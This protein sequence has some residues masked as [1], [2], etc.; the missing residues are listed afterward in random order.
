MGLIVHVRM[1]HPR[2]TVASAVIWLWL[3]LTMTI[4]LCKALRL[5]LAVWLLV[6]ILLGLAVLLWLPVVC[7]GVALTSMAIGVVSVG[8]HN[9]ISVP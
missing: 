9:S 8:V 7:L 3:H 5:G 6:A 4:R 1:R 2:S